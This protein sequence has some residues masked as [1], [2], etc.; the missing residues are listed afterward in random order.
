MDATTKERMRHA[1]EVLNWFADGRDVQA[2]IES[3]GEWVESRVSDGAGMTEHILR[4]GG[5][6][7]LKPAKTR[8]PLTE[9]E[10]RRLVGVVVTG[11]SGVWLCTY[12]MNCV[13]CKQAET[14][15]WHYHLPGDPDNLK[16][17]WVEE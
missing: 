3:T 16:P 5:K 12:P 14:E 7:R 13:L 9:H 11:K 17:C 8:R 6:Y 1:A 10:A 2:V 15:E 4:R